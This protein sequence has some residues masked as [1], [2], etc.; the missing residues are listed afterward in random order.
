[1]IGVTKPAHP[2]RDITGKTS[3]S[4]RSIFIL[5]PNNWTAIYSASINSK[6]DG[7]AIVQRVK[8]KEVATE[9]WQLTDSTI[10]LGK[11]ALYQLSYAR[12]N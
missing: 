1:M 11:V 5:Y 12:L 2:V 3:A 9:K 7:D 4:K 10:N 8:K 6:A